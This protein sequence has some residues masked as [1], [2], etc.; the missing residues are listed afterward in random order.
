MP[1]PGVFGVLINPHFQGAQ[2]QSRDLQEAGRAMG[3]AIQ[4]VMAGNDQEL[5]EA[6]AAF[7]RRRVAALLV[8]ADPYFAIK[9]DRYL[10]QHRPQPIRRVNKQRLLLA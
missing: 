2:G 4:I 10:R 7:A 8:A 9:R 5:E 6:F 3:R 1:V